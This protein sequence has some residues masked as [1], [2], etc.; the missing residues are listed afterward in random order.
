LAII[1]PLV[2]SSPRRREWIPQESGAVI[3]LNV[4]QVE[5]NDLPKR[6]RK[7]QPDVWAGV[8]SGLVGGA[9]R[10]P[11]LNL[12]RDAT[13]IT[14]GIDDTDEGK[15]REFI[16]IQTKADVS[17]V[18]RAIAEDKNAER[19]TVD[20]LAVWQIPGVAVARVGPNTLAVGSATDVD[21]LVEVRLGIQRDLKVSGGPFEHFQA[22]D[23]DNALRLLSRDP[24]GLSRAFHPI[25]T[26]ELLDSCQ[27]LGLV[28][29]LDNPVRARLLLKTGS[30][31]RAQQLANAIRDDAHRWLHL[32]DSDLLLFADKPSLS[33]QDM[34]L[35]M[36]FT[37]PENSARLLLQRLAKTDTPTVVAS[38]STT[39]Q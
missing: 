12:N 29:G 30:A 16:L 32:A 27:L 20:G 36:N 4:E 8:W 37:V 19:R 9:A 11:V 1:L 14:R 26:R 21:T 7:E 5:K 10:A 25:F 38:E 28:L 34:T 23:R 13:R 31:E 39:T 3:S 2:L 18:I 6:W 17:P 33:R 35:E 22:F 15:R 24:P